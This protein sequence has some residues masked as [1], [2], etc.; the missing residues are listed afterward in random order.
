MHLEVSNYIK[1]R[2]GWDSNP[3]MSCPIAG[4]Q[5]QCFQPLSH[6]SKFKFTCFF[7]SFILQKTNYIYFLLIF[8][9]LKIKVIN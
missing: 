5:D 9:Y 1:W 6:L 7:N 4:F 2:R 8:D 3:R